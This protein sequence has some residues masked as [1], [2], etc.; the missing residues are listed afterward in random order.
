MAQGTN[1]ASFGKSS[2]G[3]SSF[4]SACGLNFS[5]NNVPGVV[6]L[7]L[8]SNGINIGDCVVGSPLI[9][10][11]IKGQE[12]VNMLKLSLLA[13]SYVDLQDGF[14]EIYCSSKGLAT[15]I[16]VGNEYSASNSLKYCFLTTQVGESTSKIDHV[17]VQ[18]RSKLPYRKFADPVNVMGN[19]TA[20]YWRI[21][22]I[23]GG[24][25]SKNNTLGQEAWAEF[26]QSPQCE[27]MQDILKSKVHRSNWE[28]LIAYKIA[29][30]GIPKYATF[31][32]SQTTPRMA[33]ISVSTNFSSSTSVVFGSSEPCS[34]GVIDIAGVSILGSP[35]L[36]FVKGSDLAS[37]VSDYPNVSQ[38][39]SFTE[40]D[41][42]V[43]LSNQCSLTS[44]SR[45]E[46]WFLVQTDD[47]GMQ[48]VVVTTPN[49]GN[50][51][52][53]QV[54]NGFDFDSKVYYFRS[55]DPDV[56]S[57]SNLIAYDI[58]KY[59]EPFASLS[60]G[61]TTNPFHGP[62][63]V[64]AGSDLGIEG[65][66]ALI[67]YNLQKPSI[68]IRSPKGDAAQIAS[69]VA[70]GGIIYT[71]LIYVEKPAPI[72]LDGE[73]I[74]QP[75]PNDEEGESYKVD[76]P[77]DNLNGSVVDISAPFLDEEGVVKLSSFIKNMINNET[78]SYKTYSYSYGGY[79]LLP[80]M[81]FDGGILHSIEY[82]Y[83]DNDQI[84]TNLTTGPRYYAVGSWG[85]SKYIK[86]TETITKTGKIV[87]GSN[88]EG[89]FLVN[90]DGQGTFEAISAVESPL[91]PGD[92]VDVTIMN[93]PVEI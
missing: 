72:A 44:A 71:P 13:A 4:A 47:D 52:L 90:V 40:N 62:I 58:E 89:V 85:D 37:L 60:Q 54:I 51:E 10:Y 5:N 11:D 84:S 34:G 45:G 35:V 32:P 22:C 28:Q 82:I 16:I 55:N 9:G 43:L 7:I 18:G 76:T 46:N 25:A 64:G 8:N 77:L 38:F 61:Y 39:Y 70:A 67:S 17:I 92:R 2:S 26:E 48:G 30:N 88:A 12:S 56:S 73:L 91:Y 68:Q 21:S 24:P 83:T 3:G 19:G 33:T 75:K 31:S 42:F 41:Y 6:N 81:S 15:S 1:Y 57:M 87:A 69:R 80:G 50:A 79:D 86:R 23:H 53:R 49:T 78:G 14:Y 66:T 93:V 63:I 20:H 36:D 29:F 59:G 65:N 74:D 27:H